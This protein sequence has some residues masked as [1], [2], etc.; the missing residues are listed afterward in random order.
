M[1][2]CVFLYQITETSSSSTD[3]F[4]QH[5]S[6]FLHGMGLGFSSCFREFLAPVTEESNNCSII[7]SVTLYTSFN[8]GFT[9]T[10]TT[11]TAASTGQFCY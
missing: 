8:N 6:V 11:G 5:L 4:E 2:M 10:L 1:S 3:R 7:P 9:S